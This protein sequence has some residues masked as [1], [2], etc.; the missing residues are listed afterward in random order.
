[1][2]DEKKKHLEI[3]FKKCYARLEMGEEKGGSRYESLDLFEEITNELADISNYAFL[4][5][6]KLM[7][8]KQKVMSAE[9]T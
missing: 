7:K 9:K 8:L 4:E 1:M 2:D 6:I 5:Y 3:F